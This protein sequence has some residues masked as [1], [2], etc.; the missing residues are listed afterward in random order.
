MLQLPLTSVLVAS[1]IM[2]SDGLAVM[3]LVIV[4]V[5]V[6]FITS[7]RLAPRAAAAADPA[8]ET[9]AVPRPASAAHGA[10]RSSA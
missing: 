3:P 5:A 2:G 7:A 8:P 1:L 9:G 10:G 6:S 4:A